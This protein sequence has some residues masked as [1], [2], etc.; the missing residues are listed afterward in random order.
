MKE[1]K[2]FTGFAGCGFVQSTYDRSQLEVA[3]WNAEKGFKNLK[4]Y[5]KL[6]GI[7]PALLSQYIE[8]ESLYHLNELKRVEELANLYHVLFLERFSKI[9]LSF[10]KLIRPL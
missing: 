9:K 5:H 4:R 6:P 3:I 2:T 7:D 1:L 10:E 8:R